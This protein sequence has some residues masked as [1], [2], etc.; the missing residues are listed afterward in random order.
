MKRSTKTDT[1]NNLWA[2]SLGGV[3][4]YNIGD[5]KI[6]GLL[7]RKKMEWFIEEHPLLYN[8]LKET[9]I[10]FTFG[11]DMSGAKTNDVIIEF[12]NL[13]ICKAEDASIIE[14]TWNIIE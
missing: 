5:L 2:Y 12:V 14:L 3:F 1:R 8:W 7:N 10:E 11:Y 9:D 13:I 4:T 6:V